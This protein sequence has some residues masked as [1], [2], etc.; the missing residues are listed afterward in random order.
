MHRRSFLNTVGLA[1]VGSTLG[2]A[3]SQ[4]VAKTRASTDEPQRRLKVLMLGGTDFL[5]PTIV[6]TFLDRGHDVTL[7][8]R[9]LTNPHLFQYLEKASGRPGGDD[10]AKSRR[11]AP[12][13]LGCGNRH[14]AEGAQMR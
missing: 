12:P 7:F 9:G 2:L 8:N 13:G 10:R 1:G 6:E 3:P 4:S 14:L 11:L 5:G